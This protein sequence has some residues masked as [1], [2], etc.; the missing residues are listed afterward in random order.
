MLFFIII[1]FFFFQ[2]SQVSQATLKLQ[3]GEKM[4]SCLCGLPQW[5]RSKDSACNTG[6][7]GFIPGMG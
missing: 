3:E 7:L 6:D 1:I 4:A 2:F 5:L